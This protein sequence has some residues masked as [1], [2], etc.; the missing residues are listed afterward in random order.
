M[1]LE[2]AVGTAVADRQIPGME[3]AE[4]PWGELARRDEA[5]KLDRTLS[6]FAAGFN[7]ECH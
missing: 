3:F 6:M 1:S 2:A 4:R 5:V 7:A